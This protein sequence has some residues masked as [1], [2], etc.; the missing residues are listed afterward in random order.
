[1]KEPAVVDST[2]LIALERIDAL[3]VLPELLESVLIP[4]EVNCGSLGQLDVC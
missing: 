4:P 3:F 1:V 2:A